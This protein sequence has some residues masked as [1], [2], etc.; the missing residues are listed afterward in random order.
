MSAA[1]V[2][3]LSQATAFVVTC[4]GKPM[5]F[6]AVL[7]LYWVATGLVAGRGDV[8]VV[9]ST[10]DGAVGVVDRVYLAGDPPPAGAVDAERCA[11][12]CDPRADEAGL[13]RVAVDRA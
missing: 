9:L 13:R 10:R 5:R 6:F 4:F 11:G 2:I 1:P 12:I 3:G 8:A 7:L